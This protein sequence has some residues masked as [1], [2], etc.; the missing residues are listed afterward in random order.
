MQL[1]F[2]PLAVGCAVIA[3]KDGLLCGVFS[4]PV[5]RLL[6]LAIG[7]WTVALSNAVLAHFCA[8]SVGNLN[9]LAVGCIAPFLFAIGAFIACSV[10]WNPLKKE[11]LRYS[12]YLLGILGLY[13]I[14]V[15]ME[16]FLSDYSKTNLLGPLPPY[17]PWIR[18]MDDSGFRMLCGWFRSPDI[19]GWWLAVDAACLLL[20]A[21]TTTSVRMRWTWGSMACLVMCA[22]LLTGR[23]KMQVAWAIFIGIVILA[24]LILKPGRDAIRT[25]G[26]A[27]I[28]SFVAWSAVILLSENRF[29]TE[30]AASSAMHGRARLIRETLSPI[31]SLADDRTWCGIGLGAMAPGTQHAGLGLKRYSEGGFVRVLVESGILGLGLFALGIG[32][33]VFVIIQKLIFKLNHPDWIAGVV[34]LGFVVGN[35]FAFSIG[36]QAFGD[37]LVAFTCG[38]VFGASIAWIRQSPDTVGQMNENGVQQK[39][40]SRIPKMQGPLHHA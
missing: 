39:N 36:H 22:L 23:R 9:R 37:P 31:L 40:G 14:S 16:C 6:R 10:E 28:A 13:A 15:I 12:P 29:Y 7:C 21:S 8:H 20:F 19:A 35:V 26:L 32:S 25:L 38:V 5:P 3:L 2:I 1:A 34:F 30:Y 27:G 4:Q 17:R 33:Y 11:V 18:T 24:Q